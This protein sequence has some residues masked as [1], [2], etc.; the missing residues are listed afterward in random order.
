[1]CESYCT[2]NQYILKSKQILIEKHTNKQNICIDWTAYSK[3]NNE[4]EKEYAC[5][6][7]YLQAVNVHGVQFGFITLFQDDALF[8]FCQML[9]QIAF[10]ILKAIEQK[11]KDDLD[12][13]KKYWN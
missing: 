13:I 7:P 8:H 9:L 6:H 5:P 2:A 1:M 3:N 12:Y 4:G 11:L 10:H